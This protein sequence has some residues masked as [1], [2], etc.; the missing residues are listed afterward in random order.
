ME[1]LPEVLPPHV[2]IIV[3]TLPVIGGCWPALQRKHVVGT[4]PL[5]WTDETEAVGRD[6]V[7]VVRALAAGECTDII[8]A[9]LKS[10]KRTLTTAQMAVL[11]TAV[12]RCPFPLYIK[13]AYDRTRRWRSFHEPEVEHVVLLSFRLHSV[14]PLSTLWLCGGHRNLSQA[15]KA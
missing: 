10:D 2:R 12:L 4:C 6:N 7:A 1:W 8:T 13:L 9:W 15:L 14:I 11:T 3:S 5:P